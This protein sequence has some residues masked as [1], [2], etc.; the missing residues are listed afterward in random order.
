MNWDY[1]CSDK[2]RGV[3]LVISKID[4]AT[5]AGLSGA[6][7][8]LLDYR[9][10]VLSRETTD[11]MGLIEVDIFP[12]K[13]Y[14]LREV[15]PPIGYEATDKTFDISVDGCGNIYVDD[16]LST[17]IV[18]KNTAASASF[19]AIKTNAEDN[20]PL[21]GAVYALFSDAL[22]IACAVSTDTGEVTFKNL[23]PGTYELVETRPPAGFEAAAERLTVVVA[24]DKTVTILGQPADGYLLMNNPQKQF[25]F[26]KL[27]SVTDLPLAGAGF[28]LSQNGTVVGM[29][30][31]DVNGIVAFGVIDAG[32]YELRETLAPSGYLPNENI[33]QVLVG[34][35]GSITVA[36]LPLEAFTVRNVPE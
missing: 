9:G 6:V 17:R 20:M 11:A 5:E 27:D 24:E 13:K 14:Q 10:T 31:S 22:P 19:T 33:Y 15:S 8:E 30:I 26:K 23:N 35:D 7:F 12:C 1:I 21:A 34:G 18:I 36:G 28:Q 4:S 32:T 3:P 25:L 29:A 16:S 2:A